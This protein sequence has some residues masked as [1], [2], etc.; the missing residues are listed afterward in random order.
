MKTINVEP[1]WTILFKASEAQLK[2][3]AFD[4]QAFVLEMFQFGMRCYEQQ[5][6]S[7]VWAVG[8]V[9]EINKEIKKGLKESE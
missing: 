9:K 5:S 6:K 3:Q 4:G 7:S 2:A 8:E 1:N